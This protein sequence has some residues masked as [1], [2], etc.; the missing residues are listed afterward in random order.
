M[1]VKQIMAVLEATLVVLRGS[2]WSAQ[3]GSGVTGWSCCPVCGAA[4]WSEHLDGCELAKQIEDYER[5]LPIIAAAL[6][7]PSNT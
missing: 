3:G 2:E 7:A 4:D 5:L 1:D 6:G